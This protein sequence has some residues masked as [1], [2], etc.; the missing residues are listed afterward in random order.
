MGLLNQCV[1]AYKQANRYRTL[2]EVAGMI[3]YL[4]SIAGMSFVGSLRVTPTVMSFQP[5][6]KC[7]AY[8]GE[9]E[10][11]FPHQGLDPHGLLRTIDSVDASSLTKDLFL[12]G[13]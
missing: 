3:F 9:A 7:T 8:L 6:T 1:S 12:E 5:F 10:A 4:W 13:M 2:M 11:H